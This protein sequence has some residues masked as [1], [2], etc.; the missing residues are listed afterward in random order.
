MSNILGANQSPRVT[1]LYLNTVDDAAIGVPLASPSGS[2][3]Q[4]YAGQLGGI[5]TL[6]AKAALK[7]SLTTTGT[8][9]AGCYQYVKFKAG[10]TAANAVGQLVFWDDYDNFVVTPDVVATTT[11]LWAGV[12]L[13][14]VTK[15][16]YGFIQ[17]LGKCTLKFRATLTKVAASG[18]LVVVDSTPSNTGDVIADATAILS[19]VLKTV[20]GVALEAPTNAGL[21]L[22]QLWGGNRLN[23]GN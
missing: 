3:V 12:T 9:K 15:G 23:V 14:V 16:N 20:V 5:L 17:V 22:V 1:T 11:G 7:F 6:D 10:S 18:D 8:L 13:N 21:K 2:I 19:P 4:P